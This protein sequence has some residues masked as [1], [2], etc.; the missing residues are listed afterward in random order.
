MN[1]Y[2]WFMELHE[3]ELTMYKRS[4]HLFFLMAVFIM[5]A[6]SHAL[7]A[8]NNEISGRSSELPVKIPMPTEWKE[9][10]YR[11]ITNLLSI[12][13]IQSC[14]KSGNDNGLILDF[15]GMR[16]LLD[17]TVLDASVNISGR[18]YLGPYPFESDEVTYT[19]KRFKMEI[20]IEKGYAIL[21]VGGF[22]LPLRN[23]EGWTNAGQLVIR[24]D[25][26]LSSSNNTRAL[27]L[28]DTFIHFKKEI[29]P[30][31]IR[32][33]KQP[34]IIEGPLVNLSMSDDP[35]TLV[36]SFKT[37]Q[38]V[39][40][41]VVLNDG[42]TFTGPPS[43]RKHEITLTG[44]EAAKNYE[45]YVQYE[46]I[47]TKTFSFRTAPAAG[48]S[49]VL[50]AYAGDS[51]EGVEGGAANLM[52]VNA[53]ALERCA[54][55]AFILGADIF[56]FGGDLVSGNTT[57][58]ED[59]R[60]Q[61]N[62]WKQTMA[63]FWNHRPVY[64]SMGNHECILKIF[65]NNNVPVFVMDR[66]P[67]E[68]ESVEA[69]FADEMVNPQNGPETADPRRPI[70]KENVYSFQYGP[71]KYIAFNNSYWIGREY[72]KPTAPVRTGGC[73][74]GYLMKDQLQWIQKELQ[75]AEQNPTVKYIL[76]SAHEP[77][78]P[79][80]GHLQDGMWY[81]GDNNIK[82]YTYEN[83]PGNLK[84]ENEGI[85]EIR[86]RLLKMIS[87]NKKVAAVLGGDEHSYHKI[88]IDRH[89]PIGVPALDDQDGTRKVCPEGGACSPFK[90]IKYPT[91][92]LIS[93]DAGAP[94]YSEG[95]T[96]WNSYWKQY[97]GTYQNHDS[98]RGCYHYSSQENFFIFKANKEKISLTVYNPYGD[99]ID[100]IGNL[101]K[102]KENT[103]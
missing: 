47:K 18:A 13:D 42:R 100:S 62:A 84:A 72:G 82:P 51:R 56:T 8:G 85:I 59:F 96:P 74:E 41:S 15:S 67:Y 6:I 57:S 73:P 20:A 75:T 95:I 94:Y 93:G 29:G 2:K 27:G 71:V 78:F 83:G 86:N 26:Y 53:N 3:M 34:T 99:I 65:S 31:G 44:L 88:L 16:N 36:I 10:P 28:Y 12:D 69:V 101:M 35:V 55:Q 97:P 64:A 68:T 66:W 38:P 5:F 79:N 102:V 60:S 98:M 48:E 17:G 46:D 92:Y 23:S 22:L 76:L 33:V 4:F 61:L 1:K 9:I 50:I 45:Y 14:I 103:K 24:L 70:Y 7:H 89:V 90:D 43:A 58:V 21:P 39:L 87:E 91:W 80:G 77:I 25:L 30:A 81:N 54:N 11:G 49:E 40:A 32:F 63:G 37:D 52:G 19:Y